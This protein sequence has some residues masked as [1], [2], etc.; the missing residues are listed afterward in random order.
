MKRP[1]VSVTVALIFILLN[2]AVWLVFAILVAFNAVRSI[3]STGIF[4]WIMII[5][6]LGTSGILAGITIFLRRHN[7][8]AFYSGLVML[9]IIAVLSIADE[10][11]WIDLL[12][13][14]ISLVPLVLMIKDRSWYLFPGNS[15]P[16]KIKPHDA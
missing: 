6:A 14:T 12:S 8:I 9:V 4:K 1:P 11:G 3:P 15:D 2:A 10:F 7:R 13:L 16:D 5:P